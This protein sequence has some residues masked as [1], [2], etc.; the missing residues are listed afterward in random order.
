MRVSRS[1]ASAALAFVVVALV[2]CSGGAS[3]AIATPTASSTPA[4]STPTAAA[5]ASAFPLS[6]TDSGGAAVTLKAPAKAIVSHSPGAT[7]ILFAIGAGSQVIAADEFSDFPAAAK[8]LRK[9]KYT[10]PSPE[11]EV[12]LQPDLVILATNQKAVIE[13]F[14]R[15]GLPVFYNQEPDSLEGVIANVRLLGRATGRT[16][17]AETL[18]TQMKARIDA[19]TSKLTDVQQGPKVF[20]ELSDTLFTAAPNTFIGG[21]LT[22][23]K[24][25]NIA[26]GSASPFPQLTAE[27]V[28]AGA[29]E[30]I[31]LADAKF[32]GAPEK[33][34]TRPGWSSI[35]AVKNDR[36]HPI[37]ADVVNRP[38][39][40]IVEGLEQTAK[41]L[42][43]ERFR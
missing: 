27:A 26:Q 4:A 22:A 32:G 12:A 13:P 5:T 31:L 38:G 42:Y 43:P 39:P 16:A 3:K 24:A 18:A 40:R 41:L 6:L 1:V 36:L 37:E 8:A 14:R 33:V 30:V 20:Y 23:L 9:V 29:P 35:P 19:V 11:A 7:E 17:E 21:M 28:I 15:L 34:K 10:D 2:G 25:R